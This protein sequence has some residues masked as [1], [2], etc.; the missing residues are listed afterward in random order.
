VYWPLDL[1]HT[2]GLVI[3]V[4]VCL[5]GVITNLVTALKKKRA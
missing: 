4:A 1:G 2:T 5:L 3:A